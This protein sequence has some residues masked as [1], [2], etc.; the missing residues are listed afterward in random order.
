[1]NKSGPG[2]AVTLLKRLRNQVVVVPV[3]QDP[4]Y[5][6]LTVFADVLYILSFSLLSFILPSFGLIMKT[7]SFFRT[8][9]FIYNIPK[10]YKGFKFPKAHAI[11]PAAFAMSLCIGES[12]RFPKIGEVKPLWI[13]VVPEP[14]F[15]NFFAGDTF[16]IVEKLY[17][18]DTIEITIEKASS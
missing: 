11:I 18:G 5:P 7:P 10:S 15:V 3:F 1:M 6:D 2:A 12:I 17:V 8:G 9:Y 14:F 16:H 4:L 13:T